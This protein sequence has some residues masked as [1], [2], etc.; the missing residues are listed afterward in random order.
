[1]RGGLEYIKTTYHVPAK[2]GGKVKFQGKP[3]IITGTRG[4][5]VLVKFDGESKAKPCHPTWEM[6]YLDD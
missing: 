1:M 4:P 5:H 3:G 2:R 6:E